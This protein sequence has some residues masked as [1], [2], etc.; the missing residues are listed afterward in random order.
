MK[1]IARYIAAFSR[2]IPEPCM[3][4]GARASAG[5]LCEGCREDLPR[6]PAV[7]CPVCAIPTTTADICGR[8]LKRTPRYDAVSAGFLYAFPVDKLIARLKFG[9]TLA[10]SGI[11]GREMC[12]A[13]A[14]QPRPDF[15]LAVPLSEERLRERGFN[16]ASEIAR[17]IARELSVPLATGVCERHRHTA[18]Q[19]GQPLAQRR[20]NLRNAFRC[21]ASVKGARIAVVD[22]VMTSGATL[23]ELART[24]KRAGAQQ[25]TG[26]IV[27][28]TP[29]RTTS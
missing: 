7:H 23:D 21:E 27:A 20:A 4:C 19:M 9:H 2:L 16:Q 13:L 29:E 28:R 26:W 15:V 5:G 12:A 24:L 17:V 8:C 11:L 10:V 18:P 25:V 3:L 1:S 14:S 22:D 6:L